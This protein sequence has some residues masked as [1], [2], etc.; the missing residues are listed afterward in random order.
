M[1]QEC[2]KTKKIKKADSVQYVIQLFCCYLA[3]KGGLIFLEYMYKNNEIQKSK[4]RIQKQNAF[5]TIFFLLKIRTIKALYAE[6]THK[7]IDRG[8]NIIDLRKKCILI[9]KA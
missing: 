6:M 7:I 4:I 8:S 2:L 1:Q 5:F 9:V 3:Q